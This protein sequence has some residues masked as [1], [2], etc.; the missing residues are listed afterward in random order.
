M[1]YIAKRLAIRGW[2]V[3]PEP[4]GWPGL[5][6]V[7]AGGVLAWVDAYRARGLAGL[8]ALG[9][10]AGGLV[11]GFASDQSHGWQYTIRD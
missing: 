9:A 11:L 7:E 1:V 5:K 8:G 3:E 4:G 2:E 10:V 6:A